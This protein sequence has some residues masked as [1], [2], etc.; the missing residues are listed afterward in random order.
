VVSESNLGGTFVR[1]ATNEPAIRAVVLFG[2][3]AR[4]PSALDAARPHSD[5]DF[6]II[7][8]Q[9]EVFSNAAWVRAAGISD[10]IAYALRPRRVGSGVK[11]S[12]VFPEGELELVSTPVIQFLLVRW[13]WRFGLLARSRKAMTALGDLASL[14]RPGYRIVKGEASWGQ[15]F[16]HVATAIP[17]T[18]LDDDAIVGIANRFVCDYLSAMQKIDQGELLAAQRWLHCYIADANFNLLHELKERRGEKSYHVA[19]RIEQ[20]IDD[21]WRRAVTVAALPEHHSLRG[22]VELSAQTCCE[23]VTELVGNRWRWPK[24]IPLRLRRE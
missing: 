9:P 3:R 11:V 18:R 12:A 21:R 8:R 5:W 16:S 7:T 15:L 19:R 1:W 17:P 4:V 23:L 13:L 24:A 6:Q 2:S 14:L 10:P 20:V 22:A